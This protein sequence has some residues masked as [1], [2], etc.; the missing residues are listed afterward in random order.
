MTDS[1]EL[2]DGFRFGV[3]TAGFQIEGGYN[4]PG[5]PANN[6][7]WWEAEGR[8]EPSGIALDFWNDFERHLD[9]ARDAGCDAFRMSIEW[10]RCEP[11]DGAV[12]EDAVGRYGRILDACHER[13]LQPLV[14]LHHFTHPAWLGEDF[15]L[16]SDAPDRFASWVDTAI[17]RFAG[18]CGHWITLNEINI[19]ALQ[20][21][22]LGVFPPGHR[23]D[24][25]S[26]VRALD[27]M[28]A[29]HVTAYGR[30]KARQPQAVV[31]TNNYTFSIYELDR[32]LV[33]VLLARSEGVARD[34]LGRWLSDRR[35]AY[36]AQALPWPG[37]I[38]SVLRRRAAAKLPLD[39]AVPQAVAAVYDSPFDR[40]LDV[41]AID[42][43]DPF[44]RRHLRL[45]GHRT[46]GGRNWLPAR[47]LWDDPPEPP[48]LTHYCQL[49]DTPGMGLLVA[50]NGLCN[51]VVRGRVHPRDD[52]WT[53][54][55]Y[56]KE[57]LAALVDAL[58]AGVPVAGYYHWTLADN[59]EW[60]SY[61]P[62][63]GLY[64]IDR[65]R[66]LKWSDQDSMGGDAAMTYRR[67]ADGLREGDLTVLR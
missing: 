27:H 16:R 57:H 51:R 10:A 12:D 41:V 59:Y 50:E 3:A 13:G 7:S 49:N 9:R 18:R 15:W 34:D 30:I 4:G 5:E 53:R 47:M 61:E 21:Y 60:G 36:H 19:Y 37:R 29:A 43:Y 23:L 58:Q 54:N 66:G 44:V 11:A 67:I 26:T 55:R 65:D 35:A 63:F 40:T 22:L 52:G 32:M 17:E 14:T 46:A 25:A 64:G 1:F 6:W 24:F 8:V 45:P 2:P 20:T 31:S 48:S 28:L 62:R 56:L 33:D 39:H 38:E 42:Q